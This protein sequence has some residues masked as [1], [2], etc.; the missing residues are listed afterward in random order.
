MGERFYERFPSITAAC[1]AIGIDPARDRIPV[2][3]GGALR[4][5]R[6]AGA[7]RRHDRAR[8]ALRR[9]RG[10]LH[11]RPRRQP[12]GVEQPHRERRRRHPARPRPGVGAA[13]RGGRAGRC[14]ARP[15]AGSSTRSPRRRS[16][17]T[18]SRHVGVL[19]D[20]ERPRRRA[21]R[22][23]TASSARIDAGRCRAVAGGVG[24]DEPADRG[25]RRARRGDG[26]H[27]EPRLPPAQR[28]PRADARVGGAPAR[29]LAVRRR[30][31]GD[32]RRRSTSQLWRARHRH[33]RVPPARRRRPASG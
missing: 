26:A 27:R 16:A 12:A 24:G 15:D 1:R 31:A 10:V 29:R 32:G 9:R 5:R 22:R 20:A 19:R 28:L 11:R 2:A 7:T 6:R 23:S 30:W 18:M 33:V 3:P 21:R 13:R 14:D 8:R 25:Q 17:P 4:L